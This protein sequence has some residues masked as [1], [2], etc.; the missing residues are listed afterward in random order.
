MKCYID[1]DCVFLAIMIV[2]SFVAGF[3]GCALAIKVFG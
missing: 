1:S 2:G 3:L